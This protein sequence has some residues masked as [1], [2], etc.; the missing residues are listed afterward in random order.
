MTGAQ[1]EGIG[2]R[3]YNW[4][5]SGHISAKVEVWYPAWVEPSNKGHVY[6][7]LEILSEKSI[8]KLGLGILGNLCDWDSSQIIAFSAMI[9]V[10]ILG[11]SC[12]KDNLSLNWA[13]TIIN[14]ATIN[15]VNYALQD[16]VNVRDDAQIT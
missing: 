8:Q 3:T 12:T 13:R 9:G 2:V 11:E 6:Y 7:A 16:D 5:L 1:I 14:Y 4:V 15:W 10:E